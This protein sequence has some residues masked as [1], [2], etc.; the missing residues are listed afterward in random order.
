MG[1]K[2]VRCTC[3]LKSPLSVCTALIVMLLGVCRLNSQSNVAM[4]S[5]FQLWVRVDSSHPWGLHCNNFI[6]MLLW[7]RVDYNVTL[8]CLP[9][10]PLV[11]FVTGA[12][13]LKSPLC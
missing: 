2:V 3:G 4:D 8:D 5:L 11:F 6:V 10:S 7:G 9:D 13:G 1:I 12:C